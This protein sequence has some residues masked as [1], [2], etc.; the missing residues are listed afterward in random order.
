LA[1]VESGEWPQDRFIAMM[2]SAL[3]RP[4]DRALFG[5]PEKQPKSTIN[6]EK[7]SH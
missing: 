2:D 6:L 7:N 5:L 1:K 3:F 4:Y